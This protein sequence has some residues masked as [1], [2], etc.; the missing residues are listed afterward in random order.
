MIEELNFRLPK[1]NS[2]LW[3]NSY[4]NILFASSMRLRN[5]HAAFSEATMSYAFFFC[6]YLMCRRDLVDFHRIRDNFFCVDTKRLVKIWGKTSKF[7]VMVIIGCVSWWCLLVL[8][9]SVDVV[10][11]SSDLALDQLYSFRFGFRSQW[12]IVCMEAFSTLFY[13]E[14]S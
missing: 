5:G 2:S 12:F 1:N 13:H 7:W 6:P 9:T 10:R 8:S 11:F 14:I 4:M 3:L